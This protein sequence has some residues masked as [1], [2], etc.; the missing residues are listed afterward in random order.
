MP[1]GCPDRP[2]RA[3]PPAPP[4]RRSTSRWAPGGA[5]GRGLGPRGRDTLRTR[6]GAPAIAGEGEVGGEG[7]VGERRTQGG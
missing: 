2:R 6:G 7:A 5:G 3:E 1:G 4:G